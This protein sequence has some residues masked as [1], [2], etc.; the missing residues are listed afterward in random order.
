MKRT[1]RWLSVV[2]MLLAG[3]VIGRYWRR[4]DTQASAQ[5]WQEQAVVAQQALSAWCAKYERQMADLDARK[6]DQERLQNRA[7]EREAALSAA[8]ASAQSWQEQA[9]VARQALSAWC[10]KYE[11]QIAELDARKHDQERLQNRA[12]ELEAALSAAQDEVETLRRVRPKAGSE[13]VLPP[14]AGAVL[15][16][17]MVRVVDVNA[18]LNMLVADAGAQAGMQAGMSFC[19]VHDK[20]PVADVHAA[21]VRETFTGMVIEK[22]YAGKQPVPGDRLIVRKK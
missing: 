20:T 7:Q 6:R 18:P 13:D 16:A 10:A 1:A 2:V 22:L 8:Q 5:S 4:Q 9:V 12:R 21:D 19:V 3:V 14:P 11:R 15:S 17:P